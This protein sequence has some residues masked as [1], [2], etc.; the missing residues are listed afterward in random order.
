MYNDNEWPV[1]AVLQSCHSSVAIQTKKL[2]SNRRWRFQLIMV[3]YV[4]GQ[5]NVTDLSKLPLEFGFTLSST[6]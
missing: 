4:V 6:H 3:T 1:I 2:W 5:V